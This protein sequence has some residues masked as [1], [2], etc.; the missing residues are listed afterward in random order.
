M[1]AIREDER[2]TSFAERGFAIVDEMISPE[3]VGVLREEADRVFAISR[4]RG[5]ARNLLHRSDRL[6]A[7]A[8]DGL[9]FEVAKRVLGSEAQPTKLTLFNKT[10]EANWLIRWHQDATITVRE[11]R[12]LAGYSGWSVKE[13]VVHVHPPAEVLGKILA[14]RL[15]LDDTPADNGALRVLPGSHRLGLVSREEI[16][17]L[18]EEIPEKVCEVPCSG[19]MIMSPLLLHASAKTS[20]P[21]NRRVLHFEYSAEPPGSGLEWA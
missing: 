13:G 12:E 14:I 17:R 5:G 19:M 10:A 2:L 6:T 20:S 4:S 3:L 9:P 7:L 16:G 15:H 8:Q 21:G 18:R 1:P 11:R